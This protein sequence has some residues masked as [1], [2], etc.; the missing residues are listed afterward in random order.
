M[1]TFAFLLTTVTAAVLC[2]SDFRSR[3]VSFISL[4][5]YAV[6]AIVYGW[7]IYGIWSALTYAASGTIISVMMFGVVCA[8]FRFREGKDSSV[9][10]TKIGKGDLYFFI[11]STFIFEPFWLVVFYV[12]SGIAGLMYYWANKAGTIPLI[13]VSVPFVIIYILINAFI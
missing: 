8:Y 10:D 9:V 12:T 2:V 7:Q 5:A 4:I 11:L 13:G 3:T 1:I 6:A